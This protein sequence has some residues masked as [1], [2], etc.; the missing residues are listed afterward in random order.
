MPPRTLS[1]SVF[2]CTFCL[3]A[4][5]L[6][7]SAAS[8]FASAT[9]RFVH[10]VPGAEPAT[11]SVSVSGAKSSTAPVSFGTASAPL[12]VAAGTAKMTA[13]AGGKTLATNEQALEDGKSYTV[14]AI[15]KQPND[16]KL[17]VSL[18]VFPD[19]SAVPGKA[20]VRAINVAPEA[21]EPD[22]R[23]DDTV[24]APKLAYAAAGD[25]TDVAPGVHD[26]IVTRAGGS[27][28]ALA[29]KKGVPLT[30]GTSTT[31][32][33]LGSG[34]A[35]MRVMTLVDGSAAPAGAPATGYGGIAVQERGPS[36]VMLALLGALVGAAVGM[37]G[38]AFARRR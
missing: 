32:I 15:Q 9:V 36:A 37:A 33:V 28:G 21:G 6:L 23:V 2:G 7:L 5:L 24:I 12:S 18:S 16:P 34:G 25:Y 31:A 20:L 8:A 13:A 1:W 30:A 10:A 38:W 14:V 3:A 19:A 11:L 22:V 17:G 27:G 26:V 35:T 29:T 4:M